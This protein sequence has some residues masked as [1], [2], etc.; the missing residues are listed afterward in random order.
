MV[1]RSH[2]ERLADRFLPRR[3]EHAGGRGIQSHD[4]ARFIGDDD[5]IVEVRQRRLQ[6]SPRPFLLGDQP[7]QVGGHG[8]EGAGQVAE[9]LRPGRPHVRIKSTGRDDPRLTPEIVQG[10]CD[11]PGHKNRDRNGECRRARGREGDITTDA[12]HRDIQIV[13]RK[14]HACDCARHFGDRHSDIEEIHV[15][16][17]AVALY[18]PDSDLARRDHLGSRSV[19]VHRSRVS[20][21]IT[22][23]RA[24][25]RHDRNPRVDPLAQPLDERIDGLNS[26]RR[27]LAMA[28]PPPP[29]L[30]LSSELLCQ[31]IDVEL[32]TGDGEVDAS[33]VSTAATSPT[34]VTARRPRRV[35]GRI[36]ARVWWRA[37]IAPR[38]RAAGDDV[39]GSTC[40]GGGHPPA[41]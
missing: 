32:A 24:V 21:R 10:T 28:P 16:R 38:V 13:K 34:S 2:D 14:G 25:G 27:R 8:V 37:A 40:R 41:V 39:R 17:R 31:A 3:T 22:E 26:L 1:A 7:A 29:R 9:L 23:H 19:V 20:D 15:E 5:T 30:C 35:R 11:S 36:I 12:R 18:F 33:A 6:S 4:R